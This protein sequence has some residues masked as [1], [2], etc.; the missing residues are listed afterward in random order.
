MKF[1]L[2]AGCNKSDP[3]LKAPPQLKC[4][5]SCGL[6]STS[7]NKPEKK[8]TQRYVL[9]VLATF[10]TRFCHQVPDHAL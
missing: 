3:D 1:S 6:E 5:A 7:G 2:F 10:K 9:L 4:S 8:I